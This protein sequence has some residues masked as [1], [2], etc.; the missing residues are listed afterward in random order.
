MSFESL[1][2][3]ERLSLF[4]RLSSYI[5]PTP[6]SARPRWDKPQEPGLATRL[7]RESERRLDAVG[8]D[9]PQATAR[10]IEMRSAFTNQTVLI[11]AKPSRNITNL[12]VWLETIF[13]LD[14]TVVHDPAYFYEWLFRFAGLADIVMIDRDSFT[15]QGPA[16]GT[17]LSAAGEACDECPVIVLS[18]DF[19][20]ND[21]A[22]SWQDKWD[23]TLKTP[24]AQTTLWLAVKTAADMALNGKPR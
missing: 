2:I 16:F 8:L 17:F 20:V 9:S 12:Q 6:S 7:F 5:K 11:L 19:E 1:K 13:G 14:V 23:I 18:E 4:E 24:V 21:F 10:E 3:P 22:P 15:D